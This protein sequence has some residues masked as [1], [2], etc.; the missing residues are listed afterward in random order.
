M[1]D[2]KMIIYLIVHFFRIVY[3]WARNRNSGF[4]KLVGDI[5]YAMGIG[6]AG[7]GLYN[8]LTNQPYTFFAIFVGVLGIIFGA[9]LKR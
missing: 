4:V 9:I 2:N 6:I 8:W 1:E 3:G 7:N 5:A